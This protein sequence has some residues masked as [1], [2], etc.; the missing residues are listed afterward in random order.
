MAKRGRPRNFDKSHVLQQAMLTFWQH[1]YEGTS[2]T[3]LITAMGLSSPSIYAAFNS[4]ENLF[5]ESVALYRITEGGRVWS[6]AMA[7]PTAR[8][9]VETMLRI[10]AEDFTQP[11]RPRGCLV[12]LGALL[13]DRENEV[14]YKELKQY[15]AESLDM[16]I[17][18]LKKGA[19]EGELLSGQDW[20][21][22]A[23]YFITVQQGMS[24]QARDGTSRQ[25]LLRIA[26]SAMASWDTLC[27]SHSP[28]K[29]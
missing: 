2:M 9:A 27:L 8:A 7:A 14:V 17:L 16:L 24:I 6:T 20:R 29:N 5:R 12:V 10:S 28:T 25:T 1:G 26:S 3:D 15:R 21:A 19:I 18:R 11:G 13:A 23:T 4:K 22:I